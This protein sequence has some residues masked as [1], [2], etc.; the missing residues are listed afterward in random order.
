MKV[1]TINN[2]LKY[3]ALFLVVFSI[4]TTAQGISASAG[5]DLVSR[6]IWRGLE[7]NKTPNIQPAIAIG[8]GNLE[9][10][11]WGSY[12]L[13]F[14]PG[15]SFSSE[16]DLYASYGIS[17]KA[18]DISLMVTDYY[19][20]DAGIPLGYADDGTGAH[21]IEGGVGFSGTEK[22]PLSIALF[23]NL[24]NDPGNNMY[25][26]IAY[27]FTISEIDFG[28]T[29]G[30]TPGSKDNSAYYGTDEFAL[31]NVG[32][33]ASKEVKITEDFSLP[34]SSSFIVNPKADIA[35]FV[36]GCSFSL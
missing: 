14:E 4:S 6:Y 27:P 1:S 30:G 5:A 11:L 34:L 35:Y 12:A 24:Y 13:S 25:F 17:T 7:V 9:V 18:G 3:A 16:I 33:S 15:A 23:Y 29:I 28:L 31:I 21:T 8:A 36:F 32:L 20:P 22:F 10:G 2:I 19:F 26:E